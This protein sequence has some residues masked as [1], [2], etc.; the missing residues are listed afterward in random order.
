LST[1]RVSLTTKSPTAFTEDDL[2][3]MSHLSWERATSWC[4][5]RCQAKPTLSANCYQEF[6]LLLIYWKR[7][8]Y[9]IFDDYHQTGK[10]ETG[11]QLGAFT[12]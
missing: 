11:A 4:A 7:H 8:L 2:Q 12:G 6:K 10:R 5:R 3:I 9:N 1:L